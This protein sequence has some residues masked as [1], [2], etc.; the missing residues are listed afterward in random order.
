M[1]IAVL[2]APVLAQ[3]YRYEPD[4]S[5]YSSSLGS[6]TE[7]EIRNPYNPDPSTTY[8]GSIDS[9]G[10]GRMRNY[11][12]DTLRGN[13]DSDGYGRLRNDDGSAYRVKPRY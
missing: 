2:S 5:P 13:I 3:T 1:S 6:S 10:S 8:R 12:G 7:V 11:Q 9:D 4:R